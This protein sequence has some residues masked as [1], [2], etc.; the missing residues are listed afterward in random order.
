MKVITALML[1]GI[2]ISKENH[3]YNK[4]HL[5]ILNDTAKTIEK[6][7]EEYKIVNENQ[8]KYHLLEKDL[9][10]ETTEGGFL[11]A[12]LDGRDLRKIKAT[13]YKETGKVIEEY[14]FNQNELFFAFVQEYYYN[15]PI[16][17]QGSK[18]ASI[19]EDRYYFNKKLLLKWLNNRK[20]KDAKSKEFMSERLKVINDG[21]ALRKSLINCSSSAHK[22][23]KQDTA[24]CKYG[25]DCPSTGYVISG[26]RNSC[27]EV[28]HVIP[29]NKNV[30]LEQ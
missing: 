30:S 26:S 2:I 5:V 10:G 12:Y 25:S 20:T 7:R 27:G 24:R 6:I 8:T 1:L 18:I 3:V 9:I 23:L 21:E 4:S 13:Y 29:Q 15:K 28:I 17:E 19:K 22:I 11:A 16:Y 14:Y